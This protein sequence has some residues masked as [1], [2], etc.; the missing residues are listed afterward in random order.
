M[1]ARIGLRERSVVVLTELNVTWNP[2]I[3][4]QPLTERERQVVDLLLKGYRQNQIAGILC[5]TE[6]YVYGI[7][8]RIR[9]KY[10]VGNNFQLI[11]R[12]RYEEQIGL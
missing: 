1:G 4:P 9:D 6:K 2:D 12:I 5:L 8:Q 7:T 3:A 11:A 10:D